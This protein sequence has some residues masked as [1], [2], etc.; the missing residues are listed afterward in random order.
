M[1]AKCADYL[2]MY[3]KSFGLLTTLEQSNSLK[4][5]DAIILA[6]Y[7][8]KAGEKDKSVTLSEKISNMHPFLK[9]EIE[10]DVIKL[11]LRF[12]EYPKV[13][14]LIKQ[15]LE[16]DTTDINLEYMIARAYAGLNKSK[17]ALSHLQ[18]ADNLGFN[19]GFVYK[20]DV[21]FDPYRHLN[22]DWTDIQEKMEGITRSRVAKN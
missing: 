12:D 11:Y 3:Q 1:A 8:M 19:L 9:K 15:Y 5:E 17:E 7:Y 20:N 22:K 10:K 16:N 6:Q 14:E 18:N 2:Y 4:Y 13:I 21:L